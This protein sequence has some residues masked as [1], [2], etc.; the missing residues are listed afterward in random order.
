MLSFSVSSHA[1]PDG[2][3]EQSDVSLCIWNE[4]L[5][6]V[7][8]LVTACMQS[9]SVTIGLFATIEAPETPTL[10]APNPTVR[11]LVQAFLATSRVIAPPEAQA[12]LWELHP[13]KLQGFD[14]SSVS[15]NDAGIGK[16]SLTCSE[17]RLC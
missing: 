8:W 3:Q 5:H 14:G 9:L 16:S 12:H 10:P 13:R 6:W 2:T 7:V 1:A 17:K 15:S 11:L 4:P